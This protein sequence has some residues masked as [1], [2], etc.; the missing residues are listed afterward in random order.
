MATYSG[1]V[2][3]CCGREGPADTYQWGVW[4]ALAVPGPLWVC[5]AH[6]VCAFLV[7]T[8]Q[9]PGCSAGEMSK[10]GPGWHALPRSKPL[11]FRFSRTPQRHRLGLRFMPCPGLSSSGGQVLAEHA[12]RRAVRLFTSLVL[13]AWFPGRAA[14][15]PCHV[16]GVS[17]LWG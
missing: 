15:A 3:S 10:A 4:G 7:Y 9:A 1:S 8:A 11:R 6:G 2:Q 5:P 14:G 13:F 17:P 12:P 16:C